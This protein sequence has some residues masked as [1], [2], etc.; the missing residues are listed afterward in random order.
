MIKL[1][2]DLV[3]FSSIRSFLNLAL[4]EEDQGVDKRDERSEETTEERR[5]R[6][7]AKSW[8]DDGDADATSIYFVDV[9]KC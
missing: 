2:I 7:W 3:V 5:T 4:Q 9:E 1:Y 8:T 6:I